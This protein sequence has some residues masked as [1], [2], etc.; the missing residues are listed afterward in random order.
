MG[1]RARL[2]RDKV[3]KSVSY[4]IDYYFNMADKNPANYVQP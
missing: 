3:K 1:S 4:D 2:F